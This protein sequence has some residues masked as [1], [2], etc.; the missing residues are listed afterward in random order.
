MSERDDILAEEKQ[1]EAEAAASS[2]A[3][4]QQA[5]QEQEQKSFQQEQ[6]EC[7]LLLLAGALELGGKRYP[8]LANHAKIN[9]ADLMAVA[10]PGGAVA[11]KYGIDIAGYFKIMGPE[12]ALCVGA[13]MLYKKVSECIEHDTKREQ[14]AQQ[15]P[16]P[17]EAVPSEAAP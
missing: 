11:Q 15:Q 5:A 10:Q 6:T 3:A 9:K 7:I 8:S 14:A 17:S 1:R 4:Q 16:A 12:I 13:W 2:P